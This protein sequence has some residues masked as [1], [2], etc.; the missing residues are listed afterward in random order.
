VN[1]RQLLLKSYFSS[2]RKGAKS[3][4]YFPRIYNS[5]LNKPPQRSIRKMDSTQPET[6]E[7][8]FHPE[9][10]LML[11]EE[12]NLIK[13][14]SKKSVT[15]NNFKMHKKLSQGIKVLCKI[16][17]KK[18]AD[19]VTDE[20]NKNLLFIHFGSGDEDD[21]NGM[22]EYL[23]PFGQ[24]TLH[25]FPGICYG[26]IEFENVEQAEALIKQA[27]KVPENMV[28][29]SCEI[30]F[31]K[32]VRNVFFFFTTLSINNLNRQKQTDIPNGSTSNDLP[33]LKII[34]DFVTAE[35]EAQII[36]ECD[37]NKW[38]PLAQ[39]KV[40]HYGYEFLYGANTVNKNKHIGPLP[41]FTPGLTAK[42]NEVGQTYNKLD[43][44]QLTINDYHPGQ[45]IPPHVDT[46]SPF[47]ECLVALSLG[48]GVVMSFKNEKGESKHIFLPQRSL[49]IFTQEARFAFYHSIASRKLDRVDGKLFF[50]RRRVSL[51]YR[52]V[53][54]TA[55]A[56]K[57][58]LFCD[59]QSTAPLPAFEEYKKK[60]KA[61]EGNEDAEGIEDM[62]YTEEVKESD[63]KTQ[64]SNWEKKFVY[65]TYEKIAPHFSSTRHKAWP[66]IANFLTEL[67]F[68]SIV[69]DV[70]CGNG[71]YLTVNEENLYTIGT[72]RAENFMK[73]CKERN[74][75]WQVFS[76]D[77]L[78]L[79]F[80]DG[81]VDVAISIAVIHHFSNPKLRIQAI[82]ELTRIT[83][84]GGKIL[85]Y[86]WAF[87][88]DGRKF[89]QQDVLVPWHL[90]F[91]FEDEDKVNA[92]IGKKS[93]SG[94]VGERSQNDIKEDVEEKKDDQPQSE[95]QSRPQAQPQ[96][97]E[98]EEEEDFQVNEGKKSLV[99]KRYY[100]MFKSGE[101]EGL[102]AEVPEVEIQE[103]FYDHANWCVILKKK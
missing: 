66:R 81:A 102:V 41:D 74:E 76:A 64:L 12:E 1:L 39:R 45:G 59:S 75:S 93:E 38:N 7:Y 23:K 44:D 40:Q 48:S 87:E 79:P 22:F 70:G 97:G 84:N 99:Y 36:K 29:N 30:A 33:G 6:S 49:V 27:T 34:P 96:G 15:Y 72:D 86:V 2:F 60:D 10:Q 26:L 55:C 101:L 25:I 92:L 16:E 52:T 43:F 61:E 17:E 90:Q 14:I 35:E 47:E 50:R 91:K 71:K 69:A 98:G 53:K 56:C 80:R 21:F 100:H 42:I 58:P 8:V 37:K 3:Y 24:N 95:S 65:K 73:I 82:K 77:S 54:H 103:S 57:W 68:G 9:D 78:R 18:F 67:P 46:H 32:K 13:S 4:F 31:G 62:G 63:D 89:T 11:Q 51:T 88:Q 94:S 20:P 19:M 5:N 83:R 28:A 85:I